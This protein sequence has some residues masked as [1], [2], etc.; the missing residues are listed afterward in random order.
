[1]TL[2]PILK[3]IFEKDKSLPTYYAICFFLILTFDTKDL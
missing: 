3:K 2:F 1:M